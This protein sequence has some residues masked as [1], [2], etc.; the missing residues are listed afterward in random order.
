MLQPRRGI[1]IGR[2]TQLALIQLDI[3]VTPV[4]HP[5][6]GG[7]TEFIGGVFS[8]YGVNESGLKTEPSLF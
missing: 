8:L 3:E 4:R 1:A 2:D 7:Q 6:Y 5:S